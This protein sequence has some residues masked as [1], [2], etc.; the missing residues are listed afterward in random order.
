MDVTTALTHHPVIQ[1]ENEFVSILLSLW[2]PCLSK[3]G[4]SALKSC[5]SFSEV[6]P[7]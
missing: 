1:R 5:S 6:A 7:A 4:T 2:P 3:A